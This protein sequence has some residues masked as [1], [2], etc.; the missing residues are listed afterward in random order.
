MAAISVDEYELQLR[1]NNA[2]RRLAESNCWLTPDEA[3][4][5]ARLSKSH[6]LRLV[7]AGKG[8]AHAGHGRLMRFQATKID[9]WIAGG[10]R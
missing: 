2:A 1:I 10:L 9:S 6:F 8:P 4:A 3:A 5:R 7:R